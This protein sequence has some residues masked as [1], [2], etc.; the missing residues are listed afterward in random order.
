MLPL[1]TDGFHDCA[2]AGAPIIAASAAPIISVF[3]MFNLLH[4]A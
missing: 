2:I 3:I 4:C 1:P